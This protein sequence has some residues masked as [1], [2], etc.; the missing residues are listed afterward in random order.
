[1]RRRIRIYGNLQMSHASRQ[2]QYETQFE[3]LN[4]DVLD[5][6]HERNRSEGHSPPAAN[7]FDGGA[8]QGKEIIDTEFV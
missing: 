6:V 7:L 1:M 3:A 5:R 4:D 2:K 8:H